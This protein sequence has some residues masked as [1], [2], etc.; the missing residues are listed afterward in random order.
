MRIVMAR[1]EF[2]DQALVRPIFHDCRRTLY[3]VQRQE[4]VW[5]IH[6]DG[7]DYGPYKSESEA[8]LFAVDA[9]NKLGEQGEATQVVVMNDQGVGQ[10]AWTFGLD[11]YPPRR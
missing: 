7:T 11:S 4:D 3:W 5:F 1:P 6:F 8:M 9:A 2:W 10:P